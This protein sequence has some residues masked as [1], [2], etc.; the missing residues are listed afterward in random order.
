MA[1]YDELNELLGCGKSWATERAEKALK[2]TKQFEAG[3]LEKDEFE[4]LMQDLVRT[5][6]LDEVAD[7]LAVKTAL[8]GAILL[9]SKVV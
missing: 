5:D 9:A 2:F 6:K 3:E 8:V 1:G 7:D 4:E